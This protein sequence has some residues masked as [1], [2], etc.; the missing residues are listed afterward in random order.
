MEKE[1]I[2]YFPKEKYYPNQLEAMDAINN[3]LNKKQIVLFEGACGTGKTLS[4]LAPSLHNA[5][6]EKKTVVVATNVHQQMAQFIEEARE[7]K[8]KRDI[9]VIVL[10]GKMLMC[11]KPGMDNDTCSLLRDNTYKLIQHKRELST[12]IDREEMQ[13][14]DTNKKSCDMLLE[15]L[16]SDTNES[17]TWLFAGVR[18]PEDVLEWA[19]YNNLCGYELL[20]RY[21]KE[22]DLLICN[23]NHFLDEDI[24]TKVLGWMEK[25]LK[26]II[27]IFD[28]AHNLE[29]SA[30]SHSSLMLSELTING[31]LD[32][33]EANKDT[34]GS[35]DID[36]FLRVLLDTLSSTYNLI[37]DKKFGER[38][39]IGKDWYDLRIADPEER[40]DVFRAKLLNALDRAGIKKID[41]TIEHIRGLGV[42][43][44]AFYE[45]QFN[46]GKSPVKKISSSLAAA[47]FIHDYMKFSNDRSYFPIL[48][49]RRQNSEIYG[50]LELFSCI[51]KN[52]TAP[53]FDGVHAAVL[54]S[55]TLAPF[56]TIKDTLGINRETCELS[57]GLTFPAEKR[58]TISVSVPPLFAKDRDNPQTKE[59]I[60]RVLTDIIEQS[61]GNVLIFFPSYSEATQYKNRIKCDVPVFLDEVG[62][63]A[64]SIRDEFFKIGEAGKKAVLISY[65]WGTLTEGV[66]YRDGRGR[67]VVIVGVGYPALNDRTRAVE[68]AYEALFGHGW[69]YAIEIPTIRKVRQALGRVVRSPTDYGVRVLLD[70]RYTSTS[71]KKL[72]K[73]SVFNIFPEEERAEI[74]DV[75]PERVKYS[76]MNFFNSISKLKNKHLIEE[77]EKLQLESDTLKKDIEDNEKNKV[78]LNEK[79]KLF[80]EE[81]NKVR[82][83]LEA[84]EQKERWKSLIQEKEKLQIENKQ[85]E[86][87]RKSI[88]I[89]SQKDNIKIMKEELKNIEQLKNDLNFDIDCYI[90]YKSNMEIID[91][92]PNYYPSIIKAAK[93]CGIF[94][95]S[96]SELKSLI[97][98]K[99][100][101]LNSIKSKEH[102][103]KLNIDKEKNLLN[104]NNAQNSKY[105]EKKSLN[106]ERI[107]EIECLLNEIDIQKIEN[108][109]EKTLES[110]KN[111][112]LISNLD[113]VR[114][115]IEKNTSELFGYRN[116]NS[117]ID[118][119]ISEIKILL[120]SLN[121]AV[122]LDSSGV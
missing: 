115:L 50:R 48:S 63:S 19:S 80:E 49:V 109:D 84:K 71:A 13:I 9:K 43:I 78:V 98:I 69:D 12:E 104:G 6:T 5:K 54:M 42:S 28:E 96:S 113:V 24:R 61:D 67:T 1:Y 57:Y 44:D 79:L 107:E 59:V 14:H 111:N 66:D 38:E 97:E 88:E 95:K 73:Y 68:S 93:I 62:V 99:E 36:T 26:D 15:L 122:S 94:G 72:G 121:L 41:E 119:R 65:M 87:S 8:K 120:S 11:P 45:K 21:L 92:H 118:K 103:L 29:S 30:R 27:V 34:L 46:E 31:A 70:G 4:A 90:K 64:Q 105:E 22:A 53:L 3:A 25:G 89:S 108:I 16:T 101:E 10:K 55:A 20:K 2:N 106:Y 77:I 81:F 100:N 32:E 23:Y 51:P 60:T 85:L 75:E 52:V 86:S 33:V 112:E 17:R 58:R 82:T 102:E 114:E 7:I 117:S 91:K 110:N 74:I 40:S 39:R 47:V 76:V 83:I 37:L 56:E 35:Q 116:K 18:T